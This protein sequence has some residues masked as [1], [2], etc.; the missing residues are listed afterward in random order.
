[1]GNY[2]DEDLGETFIPHTYLCRNADR[3]IRYQNDRAVLLVS[4][5]PW[6]VV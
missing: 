1:M 4:L 5:N 2:G 6:Y 3:Y